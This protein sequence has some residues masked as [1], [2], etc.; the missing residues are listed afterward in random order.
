MHNEPFSSRIQPAH[1]RQQRQK[2]P[3]RTW[4]SA[5]TSLVPGQPGAQGTGADHVPY[6]LMHWPGW[7]MMLLGI[8]LTEVTVGFLLS[9][10]FLCI[11][12]A[13][14]IALPVISLSP[15][16]LNIVMVSG[17]GSAGILLGIMLSHLLKRKRTT[18]PVKRWAKTGTQPVA[19][20]QKFVLPEPAGRTGTLFAP[21]G[22][23]QGTSWMAPTWNGE[24]P[25]RKQTDTLEAMQM[26]R[27]LCTHPLSYTEERKTDQLYQIQRVGKSILLLKENGH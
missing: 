11:D 21:P 22:W 20:H 4:R 27:R 26:R 16:I 2:A 24:Q 19:P 5:I 14:R 8:V 1:A 9:M 13:Q 12:G 17:G 3:A 23:T 18:V 6:P 25:V 10:F 7:R 15:S